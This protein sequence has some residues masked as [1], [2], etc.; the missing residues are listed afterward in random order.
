MPRVIPVFV[1][2]LFSQFFTHP[3]FFLWISL[4]LSTRTSNFFRIFFRFFY[5]TVLH[6]LSRTTPSHTQ[7]TL[8]ISLHHSRITLSNI[9][10][11]NITPLNVTLSNI[12]LSNITLSNITLLHTDDSYTFLTSLASHTHSNYPQTMDRCFDFARFRQ[13]SRITFLCPSILD[14]I[15]QYIKLLGIAKREK[16]KLEN[17]HIV[18]SVHLIAA[19]KPARLC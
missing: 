3:T 16:T 4:P 1:L 19:S 17:C 12:A 11:S 9:T 6:R 8:Y 2:L 10:S 7:I 5:I 14:R 18:F 15:E 13:L